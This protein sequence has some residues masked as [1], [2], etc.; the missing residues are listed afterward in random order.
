MT[1][2]NAQLLYRMPNKIIVKPIRKSKYL[3]TVYS[4]YVKLNENRISSRY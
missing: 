2:G 4:H 1:A 3:Y